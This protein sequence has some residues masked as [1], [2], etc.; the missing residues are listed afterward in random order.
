MC[1]GPDKALGWYSD[2]LTIKL[3]IRGEKNETRAP[4]ALSEIPADDP[5]NPGNPLFLSADDPWFVAMQQ[6]R[7]SVVHLHVLLCNAR[8]CCSRFAAR[9]V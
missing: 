7:R 6:V 9:L 5:V 3:E 2:T 8:C 1:A 4:A